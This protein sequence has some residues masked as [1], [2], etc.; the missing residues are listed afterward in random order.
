MV[1]FSYLISFQ[2]GWMSA[3]TSLPIVIRRRLLIG[4]I[5]HPFNYHAISQLV[6]SRRFRSMRRSW[7]SSVP[8]TLCRLGRTF[9]EPTDTNGYFQTISRYKDGYVFSDTVG[10]IIWISKTWSRSLWRMIAMSVDKWRDF[11][12]DSIYAYKLSI[13][14]CILTGWSQYSSPCSSPFPSGSISRW[15]ERLRASSILPPVSLLS[16]GAAPNCTMPQM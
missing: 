1:V 15:P 6:Q 14:C 5:V 13:R 9:D 16:H 7:P 10:S 4:L 12:V 8:L 2:A 11:E 3:G